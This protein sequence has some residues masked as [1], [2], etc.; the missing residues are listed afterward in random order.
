MEENEGE[1]AEKQNQVID[2]KENF[3]LCPSIAFKDDNNGQ[4]EIRKIHR[5]S[6]RLHLI[7]TLHF[8]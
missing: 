7:N 5:K 2:E 4:K 6:I 1:D 8:R 3:S